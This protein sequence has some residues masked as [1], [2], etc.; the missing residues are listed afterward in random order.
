MIVPVAVTARNEERSIAACL[1]SLRRSIAFAEAR[2]PVKF[3][4]L[5]VLNDCTD[6]TEEIVRRVGA[7]IVYSTG[8][9]IEAQR[10]ASVAFPAETP[11]I[12]FSD[13]DI[14]VGENVLFE[15]CRALLAEPDVQA[16][17]PSKV[18]LRPRSRSLLA[19][20]LYVYN[21]RDGFQT[22]R[23]YFNGKCFAMRSWSA[24]ALAELQP[25]LA[26]LARDNFYQFHTGLRVDDVYLSRMILERHGPAAI[27]EVKTAQIHFRPPETLA[28][29]Y[30]YYKRMRLEIERLDILFPE[31]REAHARFGRRAL[32]REALR[33]APPRERFLWR[34][35][36]AALWLCRGWYRLE[37]CYYRHLARGSCPTWGP[38]LETK[39]AIDSASLRAR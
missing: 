7:R 11:F 27:R 17:Y 16:A 39:A 18:P 28:G 14:H 21:L 2:L 34:V 38:I 3:A 8:G 26:R 24:P 30:R 36:H 1:G 20:A 13:A 5:V 35:F 22:A 33:R 4:L 23:R 32:D 29:M 9:K 37:R 31:L 6:R 12:V 15:V 10:A 25:R 19:E